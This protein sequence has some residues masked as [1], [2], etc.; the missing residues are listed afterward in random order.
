M[1]ASRSSTEQ[2]FTRR[3]ARATLPFR[4]E[5]RPC[6]G[7][8]ASTRDGDVGAGAAELAQIDAETADLGLTL[9]AEVPGKLAA[10]AGPVV[11]RAYEG[12]DPVGRPQHA[13][14]VATARGPGR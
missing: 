13:V 5:R 1:L 2:L 9:A 12:R 14:R 7:R 11:V 6:R 10:G 8:E 3:E 4:L